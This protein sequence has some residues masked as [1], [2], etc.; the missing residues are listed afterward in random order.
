[1]QRDDLYAAQRQLGI[2]LPFVIT[3]LNFVYIGRKDFYY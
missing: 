2:G 1:M 3:E